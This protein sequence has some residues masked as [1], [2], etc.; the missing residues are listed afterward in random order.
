MVKFIRFLIFV[1]LL[2]TLVFLFLNRFVFHWFDMPLWQFIADSI[3][4]G[5]VLL[6][7]IIFIVVKKK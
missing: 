2:G 5:A 1:V 6:F 3:I 4:L 7:N